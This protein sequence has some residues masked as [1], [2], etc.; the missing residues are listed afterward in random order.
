[1]LDDIGPQLPST[2]NLDT[3]AEDRPLPLDDGFTAA[4]DAAL[5]ADIKKQILS[6]FAAQSNLWVCL[7][8]KNLETLCVLSS[9]QCTLLQGQKDAI[10]QL[11]EYLYSRLNASNPADAD[12][13]IL[14]VISHLDT[15]IDK[16]DH[17]RGPLVVFLRACARQ[18]LSN[19]FRAKRNRSNRSHPTPEVE[20]E[21]GNWVEKEFPAPHQDVPS[22]DRIIEQAHFDQIR[23]CFCGITGSPPHQHVLI[24]RLFYELPG[25]E[26]ARILNSSEN[27]VRVW[28]V[29]AKKEFAILWAKSPDPKA[30]DEL[31]IVGLVIRSMPESK[32]SAF[33]IK[34][35]CAL[36]FFHQFSSQTEIDSAAR[37]GEQFFGDELA[38]YSWGGSILDYSSICESSKEDQS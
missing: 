4:S 16:W 38:S 2:K 18:P 19:F 13:L 25:A 11:L 30:K 36:D 8:R 27:T 5:L 31:G 12:D 15:C 17:T 32:K 35:F 29:R 26:V 34:H 14:K 28:Y 22:A 20:D 1:M 7:A 24:L 23:R 3:C 9:Q 10:C 21:A 33:L 6:M 37:E